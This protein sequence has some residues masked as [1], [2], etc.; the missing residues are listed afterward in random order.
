[1]D[2]DGDTER[3]LITFTADIKLLGGV[4]TVNDTSAFEKY[5][6]RLNERLNPVKSH[7]QNLRRFNQQ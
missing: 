5:P 4:Y 2:S 7:G 1:M 6:E 3:M